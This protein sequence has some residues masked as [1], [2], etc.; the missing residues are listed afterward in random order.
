MNRLPPLPEAQQV[1]RELVDANA[2]KQAKSRV[3]IVFDYDA[4]AMWSVQ[5]QG[6]GLSYFGLNFDLYCALRRLGLSIDFLS[7]DTR[8]F[9]DYDLIL[10][11]GMMHMPDE[12]K[13]V[14]AQCSAQVLLGPR[15]AAQRCTH[16]YSCSIATS[17]ERI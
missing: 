11:V 4:D 8:D 15:T 5:P 14:F 9:T 6:Q 1:A 16:G 17:F 3:A 12:L 7:S 2:V 13:D 10:T